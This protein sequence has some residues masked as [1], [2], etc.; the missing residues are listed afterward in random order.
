MRILTTLL[1]T[2]CAFALFAAPQITLKQAYLPD[3]DCVL[4]LDTTGVAK[5]H[6]IVKICKKLQKDAMM[7][8]GIENADTFADDLFFGTKSVVTFRH[9]NLNSHGEIDPAK[10]LSFASVTLYQKPVGAILKKQM[11]VTKQLAAKDDDLKLTVK[12]GTESGLK[13]FDMVVGKDNQMI[14]LSFV[15]AADEKAVLTCTKNVTAAQLN[16]AGAIPATIAELEKVLAVDSSLYIGFPI[17][18]KVRAVVKEACDDANGAYDAELA[19]VK[20]V[21]L[22]V[23]CKDPANIVLKAVIG[24]V[25][26]DA[27][28]E[29][30]TQIQGMLPMA[31][32]M[33]GEAPELAWLKTLGM[34]IEGSNIFVSAS[35]TEAQFNALVNELISDDAAQPIDD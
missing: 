30:G 35:I 33:A 9:D 17:S 4:Y 15:L 2:F 5:D 27:A 12:E 26:K 23:L 3:A 24:T 10:D 13:S 7:L 34:T 31:Q 8:K 22:A 16:S 14:P 6:F 28:N 32:M 1:F 20:F 19:K 11:E 29:M 21:G 25:S 18:A